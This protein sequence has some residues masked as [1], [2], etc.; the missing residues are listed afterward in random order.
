MILDDYERYQTTR[1]FSPCTIKRRRTTLTQFGRLLSPKQFDRA[2]LADVE[3][4]LAMFP[5]AR[6]RHAYKSDLCSFYGW[7]VTRELLPSNPAAQVDPVK[8]PRSLP[9]PIGPEIK[10]ALLV[11]T[12]RIRQMVGLGLYAGLRCAE[13]AAVDVSDIATWST[14]PTLVVRG[15]KG[16]RDRVVPLHPELVELLADRP[17]SGPMFPNRAGRPVRA[18]SV[19]QTIRRHLL[20]CGIDATPH[21]L[22]HTF[23]TEMTRRARGDVFTVATVMG[24]SSV[25]DTMRYAGWSGAAAE[26]V[27]LMFGGDAA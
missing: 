14:P 25:N 3:E 12:R 1:G 4:F 6:T 22:R 13:I 11:G 18:S 27:A 15:G 8:V 17:R 7:S 19:S 24:H 2:T 26:I 16:A 10:V 5:A 23:A 9:R 20:R 21:Q